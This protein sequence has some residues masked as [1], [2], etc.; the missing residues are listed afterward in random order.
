MNA[1]KKLV[2]LDYD[3]TPPKISSFEVAA[4]VVSRIKDATNGMPLFIEYK[5]T[6]VTAEE[7]KEKNPLIEFNDF[8]DNMVRKDGKW[9]VSEDD[10]YKLT[11]KELNNNK[12]PYYIVRVVRETSDSVYVVLVNPNEKI[13]SVY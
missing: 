9:M 4:I 11:L 13:K 3:P 2:I 8:K 10:T 6:L 12:C 5:D 7:F 1:Y